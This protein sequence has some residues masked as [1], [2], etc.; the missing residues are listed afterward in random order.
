VTTARTSFLRSGIASQL[1]VLVRVQRSTQD[2]AR[3]GKG[4]FEAVVRDLDDADEKLR[5]TLERLRGTIVE[6]TLRPEGE[7]RRSLLDFVDESGKDGLVQTIKDGVDGAGG[8]LKEFQDANRG[9]ERET[10]RVKRLLDGE[11]KSRI[12]QSEEDREQAAS[13]IPDI[14]HEMEDHA[15]EMAVNLESLVSHFDLCVT[16]VKQL[17]GGG[18]AAAKIAGDL[19]EG[20]D[21]EE[22]VKDA[23]P[24]PISDEER[25]EM[26]RVLED[27]AGQVEEVVMEI[28]G[29]IEEMES[30]HDRITAHTNELAKG[31]ESITAAFKLLEDIGQKLPAYITRSQVF[32]VSWDVQKARIEEGLQELDNLRA[33]YD[34]FLRA[35]DNLIIEIDRRKYVEESMKK[36][37]QDARSKLEKLYE[38]DIEEREAFKKEQGDFLPVD[39]WPGLMN[40]PMRFN[41]GPVAPMTGRVPDISKSVIRKAHHRVREGS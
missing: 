30:L 32:L 17:E 4:K 15:R 36:V 25:T 12:S 8:A 5:D 29:H 1:D 7:G 22:D 21:V 3:Q 38:D 13:P 10:E 35:Y 33:F 34:G 37:V 6:A 39:I 28:R 41:I 11:G 27:D 18:E 31:H 20:V 26:M 9:F 16:A 2:T 14:L 40:G 23:P 24:I 19:P